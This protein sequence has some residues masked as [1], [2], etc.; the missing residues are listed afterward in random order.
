MSSFKNNTA[1][2]GSINEPH[3]RKINHIHEKIT[4]EGNA[5][6]ILSVI[7]DMIKEIKEEEDI[8][9]HNL[10]MLLGFVIHMD[11][12]GLNTIKRTLRLN[13]IYDLIDATPKDINDISEQELPQI[14]KEKLLKLRIYLKNTNKIYTFL[15]KTK[16][17]TQHE[18]IYVSKKLGILKPDDLKGFTK[19]DIDNNIIKLTEEKKE[20]LSNLIQAIRNG[21]NK[22]SPS[23]P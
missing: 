22:I 7:L 19:K 16:F 3:S 8:L 1:M 23:S 21:L 15:M 5:N 18:A 12:N 10:N 13:N 17:L 9:T 4:K 11:D 6:K 14:Y 2:Y 20:K